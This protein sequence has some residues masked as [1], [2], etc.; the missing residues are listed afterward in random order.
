MVEY[1]GSMP[2]QESSRGPRLTA[3]GGEEG[4]AHEVDQPLVYDRAAVHVLGD[5]DAIVVV[6]AQGAPMKVPGAG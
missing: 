1:L 2:L 4:A 5:E 3:L 6:D